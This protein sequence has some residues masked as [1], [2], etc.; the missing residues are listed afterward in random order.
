MSPGA[1]WRPP[2]R[3]RDRKGGEGYR[4]RQEGA[5]TWGAL[6]GGWRGLWKHEGECGSVGDVKA[7]LGMQEGLKGGGDEGPCG[8]GMWETPEGAEA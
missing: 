7:Y 1:T 3:A 5:E 4:G 8:V 2:P 6:R